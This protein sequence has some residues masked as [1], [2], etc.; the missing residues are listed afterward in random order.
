MSKS[1]IFQREKKR[2]FLFNKFLN[3]RNS[4]KKKIKNFNFFLI[5]NLICYIAFK[6]FQKIPLQLV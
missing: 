1:S 2:F 3:Y 5:K 6:S 4:L